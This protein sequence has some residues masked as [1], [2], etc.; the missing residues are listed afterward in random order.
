MVRAWEKNVGR[1]SLCRHQFGCLPC[2]CFI[3]ILESSWKYR[4]WNVP[5]VVKMQNFVLW[6]TSPGKSH[7]DATALGCPPPL[8]KAFA[9]LWSQQKE[10]C[11][12]TLAATTNLGQ[13]ISIFWV[14]SLSAAN[15]VAMFSLWTG[16]EEAGACSL[17][18]QLC[19][20]G[21]SP[22]ERSG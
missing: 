11:A 17:F 19:Y 21:G 3:N 5:K 2:S 20:G 10:P 4:M 22:G 6:Q 7:L 14:L 8:W 1:H 16:T 9:P 18:C 12:C 13:E 15:W